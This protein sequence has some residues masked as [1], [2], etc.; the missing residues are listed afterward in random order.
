MTPA[1]RRAWLT[2]LGLI[3]G[4]AGSTLLWLGW[5]WVTPRRE[6]APADPPGVDGEEVWLR[7]LDGTRLHGLWVPGRKNYP[8]VVLCHGY[9]KSLAEPLDVGL[10]LN[11]AGYNVFLFDFRACGK[12][13]GRFTTVGWKE[14]WD[15]QAAVRYVGERYGRGPVGVLGISM[16]AAAAIIAAAQSQEIAALVADSAYAH[17]E[18][19]MRKKIPEFAP[20]RWL[21]PFGWVSVLIGELLAGGRLRRVRPVDY[22]GRLSPRPLL[23]IHGERDS[24]IPHEQPG[25][26]FEAAGEPKETWTAPGSDHAVARLDHPE[27]YIERVLAFFDRYLRGVKRPRRRRPL[28]TA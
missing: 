25:E 20:V 9:Y 14:T 4:A 2:P 24:Y 15:V 23:F 6:A 18:G 11:Q 28:K 13:G 22:V 3:L 12:S 16:G 8:T 21:V 17:L 27:E 10:K 1:M 7:S 19:V 26:L 5:R